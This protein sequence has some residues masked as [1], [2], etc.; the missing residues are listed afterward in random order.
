MHRSCIAPTNRPP[1]ETIPQTDDEP[2][3]IHHVSTSYAASVIGY[4]P[5]SR[6]SFTM[7]S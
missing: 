6:T 5:Y 7:K 2:T 1:Q 3:A 4:V